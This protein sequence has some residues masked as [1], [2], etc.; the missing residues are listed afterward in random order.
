MFC[1]DHPRSRGVYVWEI[2]QKREPLR[3]IPARAGFTCALRWR[4]RGR[5]DHPRSRGVYHEFGGGFRVDEGSSP[6]ARGLLRATLHLSGRFRIIP[7]RA[8]FTI[9][10]LCDHR[11]AG[12]HPR[13]RGV[14]VTKAVR[15]ARSAG[16][17]P[18]A[19]GLLRQVRHDEV[20]RRIIP[21]RAGFTWRWRSCCQS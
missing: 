16:S 5:R 2:L 19:R 6:L 7:A 9:V 15:S 18:L 1:R 17:S 20:P 13:S 8:G 3:I 14:Y 21:A 10:V 4:L 12:D 11:P